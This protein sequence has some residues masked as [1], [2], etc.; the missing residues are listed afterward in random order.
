MAQTI[1]ETLEIRIKP[2]NGLTLIE[3]SKPIY[4]TNERLEFRIITINDW[5]RPIEEGFQS[6]AVENSKSM[7]VMEWTDVRTKNGIIGLQMPIAE[8]NYFGIWKIK[9]IDSR[10][11]VTEKI[12]K[13]YDYGMPQSASRL[14]LDFYAYN[15]LMID[16]IIR[17]SECRDISRVP[18]L[19]QS[20]RQ[21][22]KT[23]SLCSQQLWTIDERHCQSVCGLYQ[24]R[25]GPKTNDRTHHQ[26]LRDT[27]VTSNLNYRLTIENMSSLL[28]S[29]AA[30][31]WYWNRRNSGGIP[32]KILGEILK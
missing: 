27:R 23:K 6:I 16:S 12:F 15:C 22:I 3:T 8:D 26:P 29:M 31:I 24:I 20:K 17:D 28:R 30:L 4:R 5:L 10:N 32:H 25:L 11:G 14:Q 21:T 18:K 1:D 2:S 7:V 13:V 9:A 19:Y